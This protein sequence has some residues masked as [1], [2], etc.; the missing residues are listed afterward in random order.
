MMGSPLFGPLS[1]PVFPGP[2]MGPRPGLGKHL[3]PHPM[4]PAAFRERGWVFYSCAAPGRGVLCCACVPRGCRR[5]LLA[6]N[7]RPEDCG[8]EVPWDPLPPVLRRVRARRHG[9]ETRNT[10]GWPLG[11]GKR[12]RKRA[13]QRRP[14]HWVSSKRAANADRLAGPKNG[15]PTPPTG[16]A[17]KRSGGKRPREHTQAAAGALRGGGVMGSGGGGG[18]KAR[19]GQRKEIAPR[20]RA[21][22]ATVLNS[23]NVASTASLPVAQK[24]LQ[25]ARGKEGREWSTRQTLSL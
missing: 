13:K 25:E 22:E 24:H 11:P 1:W 14:H 9:D 16:R 15:P 6:P 18:K 20:Q 8:G 7:R 5:T 3:P 23:M 12:P 19:S 17:E 2:N 10:A 4:C 21:S